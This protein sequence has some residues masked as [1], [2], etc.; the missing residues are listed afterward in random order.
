[1]SEKELPFDCPD[2]DVTMETKEDALVH[3]LYAVGDD[4]HRA[5]L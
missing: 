3:M 2:C 1:M 4:D 5:T